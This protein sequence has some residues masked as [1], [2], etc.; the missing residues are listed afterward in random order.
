MLICLLGGEEN[1]S[2]KASKRNDVVSKTGIHI[3][4][5]P[6]CFSSGQCSTQLVIK[7]SISSIIFDGNLLLLR[8]FNL[9]IED[10]IQKKP[11]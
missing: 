6:L 1:A 2:E 10:F 5:L 11:K 8:L 3:R 4:T 9:G 7:P